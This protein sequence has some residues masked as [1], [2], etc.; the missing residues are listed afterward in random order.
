MVNRQVTYRIRKPAGIGTLSLVLAFTICIPAASAQERPAIIGGNALQTSVDVGEYLQQMIQLGE[1]SL[2][3]SQAA[4]QAGSISELKANVNGVLETVW[5]MPSTLGEDPAGDVPVPGWRERWQTDGSGVHP[6]WESRLGL[7]EPPAVTDPT[8][9]GIVGRGR[10]LRSQLAAVDSNA[11]ASASQKEQARRI[12]AS[13]N[14]V[15]GWTHLVANS[16]KGEAQPRVDLTYQWDAP[17]EFWLSTADTGWLFEVH[18]QAVNILKTDYEGDLDM[19]RRHATDLTRLIQ[20]YLNGVDAN[21]DG[22]ISP[23]QMEGGLHTA[24]QEAES[25]GPVSSR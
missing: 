24:H 14:N 11:T 13:I 10:A 19:A 6:E 9:F 15:I 20:K 17:A 23:V 16:A 22:V 2:T 4:G 21:N 5:G 25:A 18:A 7:P 3:A 8:Q 1:Q 12:L